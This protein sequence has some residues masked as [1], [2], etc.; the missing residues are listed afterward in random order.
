MDCWPGTNTKHAYAQRIPLWQVHASKCAS[1]KP[2]A[3]RWLQIRAG[4]Q[5]SMRSPL[6]GLAGMFLAQ[7]PVNRAAPN[8]IMNQH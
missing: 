2:C 1:L 3:Q 5:Q 7:R 8:L 4:D 6:D